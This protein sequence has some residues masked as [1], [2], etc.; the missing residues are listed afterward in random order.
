MG[1]RFHRKTSIFK[2]FYQRDTEVRVLDLHTKD[3]WT[4]ML[5]CDPLGCITHHSSLEESQR[6]LVS[7]LADINFQKM[8][9]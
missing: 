5:T 6:L 3:S 4:T 2:Q 8:Q 7:F 1:S 9:H